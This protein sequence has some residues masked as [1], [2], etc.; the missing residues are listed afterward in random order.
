MLRGPAA[1]PRS[2][3]WRYRRAGSVPIARSGGPASVR[4]VPRIPGEVQPVLPQ[5]SLHPYSPNPCTRR[6]GH[7]ELCSIRVFCGDC[8]CGCPELFLDPAADE[9]RRIVLAD[10][11]GQRV[12]MSV[13]Q[14]EQLVK[15]A[16]S[17]ALDSLIEQASAN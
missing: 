1:A 12:Q 17:G 11:F 16:K 10:D 2:L 13:E 8:S 14:F 9:P 7:P 4:G 6:P 3:P 5:I 15:D